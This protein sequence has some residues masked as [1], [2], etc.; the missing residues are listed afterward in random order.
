MCIVEAQISQMGLLLSPIFQKEFLLVYVFPDHRLHVENFALFL[1]Q[2]GVM[3][4]MCY[5]AV[6]FL[7]R[8]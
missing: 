4:Y 3:P 7:P 5:S 1:K 8:P 6:S 2:N